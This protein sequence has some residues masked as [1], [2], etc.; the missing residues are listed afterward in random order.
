LQIE[1]S[2]DVPNTNVTLTAGPN[3]TLRV[4]VGGT[5]FAVLEGTLASNIQPNDIVV[6]RAA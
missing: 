2:A 1:V 3:G 4:A 5:I 6:T